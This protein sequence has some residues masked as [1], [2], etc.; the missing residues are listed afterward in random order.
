MERN[1]KDFLRT[2]LVVDDE[3]VNRQM[4]GAILEKEY[5]VLYASDGKEAIEQLREYSDIISLV[6]L[7]LIMPEIDGYEVMNIIESDSEL[8]RIPVIMLTTEKSAE[9]R[10][11]QLG[12]ADFLTKPYDLPEVILA[13]VRHAIKLYEDALIIQATEHDSLTGLYSQEFF[14]EYCHQCDVHYQSVGMDAV[15]VDLTRFHMLNEMHG[16]AFADK[17]LCTVADAI[18]VAI[19][20][21]QGIACRYS[22]NTFYIYM[23]HRENYSLFLGKL[24][25]SLVP[26]LKPSEIAIRLGVCADTEHAYSLEQRFDRA[27]QA[28]NSLRN[29]FGSSFSAYTAQMYEKEMFNAQLLLDFDTAIKQKQFSVYYQPKFNIKGEKPV[30]SSAEALIRWNHP[31]LGLVRPDLF[32]PLFEENGLV[33]RLDRYVW[34][35]VGMQMKEWREK[36]G[37]TVPVSVNISRVDMNDPEL[38]DFITAVVK[39]N[40]IEPKDYFL[41]ITESAYTDNSQQIVDVVNGL[42]SKG[43]RVEMDDFG[44]GYSSLNMLSMLPIDVLKLDRAFIMNIAPNNKD[45]RMVE[46]ILDIA[47]FLE[48]PVVAEGVETKAQFDLLKAA[49]CDIIQGFYFS[50]PLAAEEFAI[51]IDGSKNGR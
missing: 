19:T 34:S 35:E 26:L 8:K 4:L 47:K 32:I 39:E 6:V 45:M 49:G 22:S 20:D 44:S 25:D 36:F 41:E 17:V 14:Y 21:S 46:L 5:I 23:A 40:G 10:S 9:V 15:V 2:V 38:A 37:F 11:L 43:F 18:R 16:R 28:C 42:R 30:L 33:S 13:R 51:L 29:Q 48:V 7:D 3:E 1:V 24:Q 50:K 12:A 27:L 31:K